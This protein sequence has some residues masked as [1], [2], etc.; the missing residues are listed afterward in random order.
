VN[1]DRDE[2]IAM[3]PK[4]LRDLA[5]D[6]DVD[7]A[8]RLVAWRGGRGLYVPSAVSS[9][10]QIAKHIGLPAAQWLVEHYGESNILVDRASALLRHLR[11]LEMH[12]R[13]QAGMSLN[14]LAEE[15]DLSQRQVLD[16]LARFRA[17]PTPDL[18]S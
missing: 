9:K 14:K 6:F 15:Y 3:L 10:H 12:E 18:F 11:D 7:T 2:L 4:M 5:S 13:N 16:R 8:M 1:T 17:D